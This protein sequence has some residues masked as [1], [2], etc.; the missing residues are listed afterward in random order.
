[1][2]LS[3]IISFVLH[4]SV[5]HHVILYLSF[6]DIFGVLTMLVV[7]LLVTVILFFFVF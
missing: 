1:M 2:L 7:T 3:V 6:K 5:I 4:V